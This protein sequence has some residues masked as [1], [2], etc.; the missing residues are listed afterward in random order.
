METQRLFFQEHSCSYKNKLFDIRIYASKIVLVDNSKDEVE[1]Q[2]CPFCGK[3]A[4][5]L[6]KGGVGVCQKCQSDQIMVY[7]VMYDV[8]C[9]S[10]GFR[11][12]F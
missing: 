12:T 8:K 6:L 7:G 10:C 1:I 3:S 2:Y 5:E 4:S 11:W 9:N